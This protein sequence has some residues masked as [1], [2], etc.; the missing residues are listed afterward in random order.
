MAVLQN[1]THTMSPASAGT[2]REPEG[3]VT[4]RLRDGTEIRIRHVTGDD[5]PALLAFMQHLSP[6]S[7]RMRFFSPACDLRAAAKWAASADGTDHIGILALDDRSQLLGHAACVRMAGARAEVAIEVDDTHRHQGLA[8]I[9]IAKLAREAEQKQIR[10]FVAEVLP[11][12]HEMLDVFHDGFDADC[13]FA[14]GEVDVEFPTSAWQLPPSRLGQP[15]SDAEMTS[16]PAAT[17]PRT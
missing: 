16:E 3:Y 15:R 10:H 13:Q 12:N 17:A 6:D 7:R 2:R 9:L 5:Q 8:T 1:P 4:A 11:E 14:E